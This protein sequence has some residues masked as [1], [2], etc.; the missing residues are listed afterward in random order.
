MEPLLRSSGLW[1][2]VEEGYKEKRRSK[3]KLEKDI[4]ND[5]A[6][7][8]LIK[9]AVTPSVSHC[10]A[11]AGKSKEAWDILR[12]KYRGTYYIAIQFNTP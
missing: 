5:N 12:R 1:R 7:L 10:I 11:N 9:Q 4:R 6:V 8:Y 2:Y 3:K